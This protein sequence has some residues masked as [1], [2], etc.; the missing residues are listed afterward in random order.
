MTDLL[1]LRQRIPHLARSEERLVLNQLRRRFKITDIQRENSKARAHELVNY[2]RADGTMGLMEILLSEYGLSND[3]GLALMCLAEALLRV[4]DKTTID[5]LIRDKIAPTDWEKHLWNSNSLALNASSFALMLSGKILNGGQS[6]DLMNLLKTAVSR[7]GEPVIRVAI[8]RAMKLMGKQFVLGESIE[9]AINSSASNQPKGTLYSFDML[10][11]AAITEEDAEKY[12]NSYKAAIERIGLE[13]KSEDILLNPGIS[14]KLSALHP[15][16]E[17][18]KS[19]RVMNELMGRVLA[20]VLIAKDL[21]IS[22]TIDAEEADRLE[23]SLDIIK[24]LVIHPKLARWAG[25]GVVVQ[26]YNKS[27]SAVIDWLSALSC[28]YNRKIMVRLVKGAYWDTEIKIAQVNGTSYYPVFTTKAATDVS[29][30]CC[31]KQLLDDGG[32][33]FPQFATHNAHTMASVLELCEN[34]K[35]FEFQRLHGMGAALHKKVMSTNQ[36]SCRVYAPVG[37]HEDLLAYLVRR[38]LENGANSSFVNQVLDKNN[39]VDDIIRDPFDQLDGLE[40]LSPSIP[41]PVNIYSPN[42]KNAKGWNLNDFADLSIIDSERAPFKAIEWK[43]S[44]FINGTVKGKNIYSIYNPSN[45]SERVGRAVEASI[46]DVNL[47]IEN[48]RP[49]QSCSVEKRSKILNKAADLYEE[50]AGQII[51]ILTREAGKVILDAVAELREAVDFLRYYASECVRIN[52]EESRVARGI[53]TC[54][55]PWNFPLA[56]FTGQ[57]SGALSAGNAVLAK[58]AEQ[59]PIIAHFAVNLLYEAGVPKS[60]LQ[61]LLGRGEIVG[62]KLVS[63]VNIAGVCFTGSTSTA[64]SIN[65]NIA[66]CLSP[67]APFIAETGGINAMIIDSTAL[68]EHAVK[69]VITS[70][71]H[72][73]GQ[74][75]SALRVLYVQ[76]DIEQKFTHMLMAAIKEQLLGCP[77]ET[78][79][80]IGPIID[81]KSYDVIS[82]YVQAAKRDGRLIFSH[83]APNVGYFIGP[84]IISVDGI[85]NLKSEIFGPILHIAKFRPEQIPSIIDNIN[86]AG[87]GLTFGLHTRLDNRV[88]LISRRVKVGNIYINRN[89][90]GAVVE[91]QP[92]GGEG[93]SGTGPKAG[94]PRYVKRFTT[95]ENSSVK[96]HP[97]KNMVACIREMNGPTGESN[98]T[99]NYPRGKILCLGPEPSD[100]KKQV[101]IAQ[102]NGCEAILRKSY[103]E[104]DESFSYLETLTDI[105]AVAFW[106]N[107]RNLKKIRIALSKRHGPIILLM[108]EENM[109]EQCIIER[110]VCIDT[111]AAGGNVTLLSGVSTLPA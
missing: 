20:L 51:A 72:S 107:S 17:T 41:L 64:R 28:K 34:R 69:D 5:E 104:N 66:N 9:K 8:L 30:I 23:L 24:Q 108:L 31:A 92:F 49:W 16:Y 4:P 76:E 94:G 32:H 35:P 79:T 11:E 63:N 98:K 36:T 84:K 106:G 81:K 21:N 43:V 14:L 73:A 78:E 91:S 29:Y 111:T 58:P 86:G 99:Y 19:Q 103:L 67:D 56:I 22:V 13:A 2:L 82:R 50:N 7:L 37:K 25:L 18:R 97:R 15:R 110:H 83:E 62:K 80:D 48:A 71:F 52:Q 38:L 26:S 100:V 105:Q 85:N 53:I 6:P 40:G 90:T 10:G 39:L 54:I 65:K 88:E 59:T 33:L 102:L 55:S 75:C 93:L 1:N 3:E 101:R 74:R 96:Q 44:S 77:W 47:A 109:S 70:A 27:A 61:L 46:E 60:T 12:F 95:S 68:L 42:R 45:P 57:I 89:Q 87:Y